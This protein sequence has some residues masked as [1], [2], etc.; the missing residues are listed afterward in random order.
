MQGVKEL[1]P[2]CLNRLGEATRFDDAAEDKWK[3]VL[4][5]TDRYINDEETFGNSLIEINSMEQLL[6]VRE[7]FCIE[8]MEKILE[9]NASKG[10]DEDDEDEDDE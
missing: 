2:T 9:F 8:F 5:D 4:D 3:L 6:D 10:L 1:S 7:Y